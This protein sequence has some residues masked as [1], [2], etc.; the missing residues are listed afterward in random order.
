MNAVCE[1]LHSIYVSNNSSVLSKKKV[2]KN[3]LEEA[4]VQIFQEIDN[5]VEKEEDLR[6][7]HSGSTACVVLVRGNRVTVANVGDSRVVLARENSTDTKNLIAIDWSKDQN[8]NDEAERQR[9]LRSGGFVTMPQ[10]EG[11]PARIWL[12]E[13]CSQIGLAMSRSVGDHA[14]KKVGVTSEPV[15]DEYSITES[16]KFFIVASD[17]VWE[18]MSSTEVVALIQKCFDDGMGA[19]DACEILIKAA[20]EKWKEIEGDYRDDITAIVVRLGGL[21]DQDNDV[22]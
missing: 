17:G 2:V 20:M 14:L 12:D 5:D 9:I 16:D 19:S 21:W 6:S 7:K 11:L 4:F 22:D 3:D 18:F 15:V 8:A 1:K 10:E 13:D